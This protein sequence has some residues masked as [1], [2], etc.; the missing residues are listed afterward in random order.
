M[1][2]N[3]VIYGTDTLIDLTSDTVTAAD[4]VYGKTAHGADGNPIV[5]ELIDGN[6]LAYGTSSCV[7][8]EATVGT[9]YVWTDY[10]GD[11]IA[12]INKA[13]VGTSVAV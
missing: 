5:G 10:D 4:V 12:I 1:A 3:K 6:D 7:V 13:V 8:G 2:I 11:D 9:A